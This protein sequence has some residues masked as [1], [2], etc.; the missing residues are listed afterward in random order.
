MAPSFIMSS[1]LVS[2]QEIEK[3]LPTFRWQTMQGQVLTLDQMSD[4]HLFNC[5]KMLYNHVAEQ[6]GLPTVWFN[7][8]Y[9]G[10]VARAQLI[11]KELALQMCVF[12]HSIEVRGTLPQ[13]YWEPYQQILMA[14]QN[15]KVAKLESKLLPVAKE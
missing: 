6:Y 7:H 10:Y 9:E 3:Y 15:L 5:L 1:F 8:K 14:L 4:R 13:K 11:P 12:I 2:S